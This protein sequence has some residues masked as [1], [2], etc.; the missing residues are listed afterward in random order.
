[1]LVNPG[2]PSTVLSAEHVS[3][4]YGR[5]TALDDVSLE[6]ASGAF[7]ALV[8]PNGSGKSTLLRV[9][10]GLLRPTSGTVR[11]LGQ[12]PSR[13]D[14]R[15]RIGYVPQSPSLQ[16][17]LPITARELV[18]TGRLARS[19]W[20]RW[21]SKEDRTAVEHA[22]ASVGL[23]ALAD[24]R[25]A[26]LS[27]GQQQ[28]AYIARALA[29]EPSLLVLDEPVAGVDAESQRLFADSLTHLVREHAACVFLVSHELGAVMADLDRVIVL[30]RS[31]LFDGPPRELAERGVSLGIH[32]EDLPL[33]LEALG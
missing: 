7:V 3:F 15:W 11:L 22:L 10:M 26:E 13:L 24:R 18:A 1:V 19:G 29:A 33:W 8:G 28:R 25:L 20:W 23:E 6:V 32:R 5:Q 31:I 12:D 4:S 14:D 21:P 2:V 30:K 16:P 27:G 17:E 9:L